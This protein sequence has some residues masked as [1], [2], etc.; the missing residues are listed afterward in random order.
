[1]LELFYRTLHSVH[2]HQ[3][4]RCCHVDVTSRNQVV[5][6]GFEAGDFQ[7]QRSYGHSNGAFLLNRKLTS[8]RLRSDFARPW[9]RFIRLMWS[10]VTFCC[11][12][13]LPILT[14]GRTHRPHL[15]ATQLD[16]VRNTRSPHLLTQHPTHF[17]EALVQSHKTSI[18]SV[19]FGR[20]S[21]SCRC[22]IQHFIFSV[23][24]RAFYT[25]K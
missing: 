13:E 20:H 21:Y 4:R 25:T 5:L 10:D 12:R 11:G 16:C 23:M 3:L 1:M 7:I 15:P 9:S 24:P 2:C 8:N 19:R 18:H 17:Q 14:S 22:T 6:P